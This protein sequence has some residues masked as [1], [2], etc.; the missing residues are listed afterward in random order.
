MLSPQD[1][2]PIF[3]DMKCHCGVYSS[4]CVFL[5]SCVEHFGG[6]ETYVFLNHFSDILDY[7]IPLFGIDI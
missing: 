7:F 4:F 1:K 6:L 5:K 3:N 2:I